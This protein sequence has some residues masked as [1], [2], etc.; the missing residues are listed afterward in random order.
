MMDGPNFDYLRT[1]STKEQLLF[2]ESFLPDAWEYLHDIP[3]SEL[4]KYDDNDEI[5]KEDDDER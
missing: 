1:L 5:V 3:K 2:A 4:P